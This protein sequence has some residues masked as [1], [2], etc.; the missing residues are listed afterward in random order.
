[1]KQTLSHVF[2]LVCFLLFFYNAL[3]A[4]RKNKK[5]EPLISV[6]NY[7]YQIYAANSTKIHLCLFKPDFTPAVGAKVTVEGKEIGTADQHGTLIFDYVP[8]QKKQHH[9]V[10]ELK[11]GDKTYRTEKTFASNARTESFRSDQL[12][13]YLDRGVYNPGGMILIRCLAWELEGEYKPLKN[14]NIELLLKDQKG[15][16]Y[17]GGKINTNDFGVGAFSI[18]LPENMPEGS[19]NIEVL[20]EK[21]SET[22]RFQVRRFNPPVLR[23]EHQLKRYLTDSQKTLEFEVNLSYT[24][25]GV[26]KKSALEMQCLSAEG[27]ILFTLP[28]VIPEASNPNR[29]LVKLL[30]EELTTLRQKLTLETPFLIKLIAKDSFGRSDELKRDVVYTR[31]P[32]QAVLELDK[33]DYPSGESVQLLAKVVDL[34]GK[35]ASKL[36]LLLKIDSWNLNVETVTDEKGVGLFRFS[37]KNATAEA[38]LF[39]PGVQP[40]LGSKSVV[41]NTPKP[42]TSKAEEPN[43]KQAVKI[44]VTFHPDYQPVEK[45]IHVD[46]T[47][48]SGSL[49]QATTIPIRLGDDGFHSAEGVISSPTW[50]TMLANLYCCAVEKKNEDQPRSAKNVGLITEGQRVTFYPNSEIEITIKDWKPRVRPGEIV[51]VEVQTSLQNAE[52]CLGVSLVD[53]A[54]LSLMNPL[55]KTPLDR[56]YNPQL[57]VLSTQGAGVLTWPVVDRNW[58]EPNR[59]IAYSDWGFKGPGRI[60]SIQRTKNSPATGSISANDADKKEKDLSKAS[61][62]SFGAGD[63]DDDDDDGGDDQN[64]A[65][66]EM[67]EESVGGENKSLTFEDSDAPTGAPEPSAAKPMEEKLKSLSQTKSEDFGDKKRVKPNEKQAQKMPIITIRKNFPKTALWEPLFVTQE[68]KHRLILKI[69]DNITTQRLTVVASDQKGGVGVT[70]VDCL[71]SQEFYIQS[72]FP[73]T[74]TYND[75]LNV[76]AF[77]QNNSTDSQETQVSL[78]SEGLE[79]ISP[80]NH[81]IALPAGESQILQW[82]VRALRCGEIQY[83]V[84]AESSGF[85]DSETRSIFCAP[86]GNPST[87]EIQHTLSREKTWKQEIQIQPESL[88]HRSHLNISFPTIVSALQG[89]DSLVQYPHG[90]AEQVSSTVLT[91]LAALDYFMQHRYPSEKIQETRELLKLGAVRLIAME[92]NEGGWG[93]FHKDEPNVYLTAYV[94]K[95]LNGLREADFVVPEESLDRGVK[96]LLKNRTPQGLWQTK[97]IYFWE[98]TNDAIDMGLSTELFSV[99]VSTLQQLPKEMATAY[100]KDIVSLKEQMVQYLKNSSQEPLAVAHAIT[101]LLHYSVWKKE[102]TLTTF[103]QS[104]IQVLLAL[105]KKGYWEPHWYQAYGGM[106]EL[107]AVILDLLTRFPSES[108]ESA[109]RSSIQWLLSTRNAWGVWHNTAG[110]AAAVKALLK[111]TNFEKEIPSQV[112]V[113][114]NGK[115]VAKIQIDPNDP[116]LSAVSLRYFEISKYLVA[117][118]NTVEVAYNGNLQAPVR[119]VLQEWSKTPS[120]ST[121]ADHFKLRRDVVSQANLGDLVQVRLTLSATKAM[122]YV[123]VSDHFPSNVLLDLRSLDQLVESKKIADYKI[124]NNTIHFY[125]NRVQDEVQITYGVTP[126]SVGTAN[127]QGSSAELMYQPETR[128]STLGEALTIQ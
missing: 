107:N 34:D 89:I 78:S 19:Y 25:G 35:P 65:Y 96:Y 117:G 53:E 43:T 79:I 32:F 5:I 27:K 44:S 64:E 99:L 86:A 42:M 40:P 39:T 28:N 83:K 128:A 47:D 88:Y 80:V 16:I 81:K 20:Y 24:A 116:F 14:R 69:P 119:L 87:V 23:I 94:L 108:T 1:M 7:P 98:K 66:A 52:A 118:P 75:T 26:P 113:W 126:T 12:F 51:Q 102:E 56:F 92:R 11:E 111:V 70:S 112:F 45:V 105:Q 60:I 4:Q 17:T 91:T 93:W 62:L 120:K 55:E 95:A 90:C 37:M 36:P 104:Q 127:H 63:D 82:T 30:E 85:V 6:I 54:V 84:L 123:L 68:G 73:A 122:S 121:V 29:Y 13:V 8:G 124:E 58:G 114:V 21:A 72:A 59:D 46:F 67:S 97:G 77:V 10:A 106:V 109:I 38:Q 31:K 76:S 18:P 74:I 3:E 49:V 48:I 41:L 57:K 33:D 2:L 103:L 22:T 15:K 71:V 110:T 115:E 61:E 125:L 50:G 100:E 9:L 101:G